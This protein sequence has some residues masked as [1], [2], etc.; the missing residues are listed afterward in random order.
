MD[1][2][3]AGEIVL[4]ILRRLSLIHNS[5]SFCFPCTSEEGM[6]YQEAMDL[7]RFEDE[8]N[9]QKSWLTPSAVDPIHVFTE[10][11]EPLLDQSFGP[12]LPRWQASPVLQSSVVNENLF[13][14][15]GFS[16][17]SRH[18]IDKAAVVVGG[19]VSA[20]P[21]PPSHSNRKTAFFATLQSMAEGELVDYQGDP[22]AYLAVP[23]FDKFGAAA[24]QVVGVMQSTIHWRSYF[25]KI[26]PATIVG[27]TVVLE[28][29]C[30]G[31]FTY[32][33]AGAKASAVGFGDLHDEGFD[34]FGYEGRF[35]TSTIKDGTIAGLQLNQD[36][37]PYYIHVYPT[38]EYYESFKTNDPLL[39]S[40]ALVGVFFFTICV[41]FF[42]D[43][44]VERRQ[45]RVLAKATQSTAIVS[46]LFVSLARLASSNC[47]HIDVCLTLHFMITWT[48]KASKG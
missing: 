19:F 34:Q 12:F 15:D 37:C 22:M 11:G 38:Q 47:F 8:A 36:G 26:L 4:F 45:K 28:N 23:I 20:P 33:I 13:E 17:V 21:G 9:I 3:C 7:N 44:L 46:S 27:I 39:V 14:L 42:Y 31:F 29:E 40:L 25:T 2:S 43:S 5:L 32:E 30:D 6:S 16:K 35:T 24:R 10:T 41:F 48:A 18:C 1:V